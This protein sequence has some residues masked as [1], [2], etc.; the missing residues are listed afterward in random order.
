MSTIQ[1]TEPVP[2]VLVEKGINLHINCARHYGK[3]VGKTIQSVQIQA[4]PYGSHNPQPIL[5]FTD[6]TAAEILADPEGNGPGH[7]NFCD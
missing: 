5:I 3:L 2:G 6:G 1:V 7:I 4:D